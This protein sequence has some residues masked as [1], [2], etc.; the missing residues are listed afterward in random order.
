MEAAAQK[1]SFHPAGWEEERRPAHNDPRRPPGWRF[2]RG[3]CGSGRFRAAT[4]GARGE[5]AEKGGL[6][7]PFSLCRPSGHARRPIVAPHE[8]QSPEA[9]PGGSVT[10][11]PRRCAGSTAPCIAAAS[12]AARPGGV[13]RSLGRAR[14]AFWFLRSSSSSSFRC[15]VRVVSSITLSY[16][17][18]AGTLQTGGM[19][20][21][22]CATHDRQMV[23]LVAAGH[24]GALTSV[25]L[26]RRLREVGRG[27]P[28]RVRFLTTWR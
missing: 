14:P 19:D 27:A 3:R 4:A 10:N 8:A 21:G 12:S 16:A 1:T 11:S 5:A 17:Q 26:F 13:S 25:G 20:F 9:G 2:G 22:A 18:T 24:S 15:I 23:F 6:R 7:G 28:P